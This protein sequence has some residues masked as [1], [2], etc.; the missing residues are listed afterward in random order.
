MKSIIL[1]GGCFWCIEAVFQRVKGITSVVSG[2]SGGETENP[3]Y[4]SVSNHVGNHAEVVQI[5]Y[6]E[7]V[8][9]LPEILE[10]FFH[11]HDPTTPN[12]Q[13]ADVGP[14]YRSIVFYAD[15]KERTI[16]SEAIDSAQASYPEDIVT[17]VVL[18]QPFYRAE[19]YHQNYYN[20]NTSQGYCNVVISPKLAKLREKYFTYTVED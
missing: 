1:G 19:E 4:Q 11:L 18:R 17:E 16:V 8:I 6:D 9:T 14:Q 3:T 7:T 15:E 10:I 20:T 13:G 12:R 5:E 2:Y